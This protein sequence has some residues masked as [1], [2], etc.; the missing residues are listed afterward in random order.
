MTKAVP[1]EVKLRNGNPGKRKLPDTRPVGGRPARVPAAPI[2]L[3]P[4]ARRLWRTYVAPLMRGGVYDAADGEMVEVAVTLHRQLARI[5]R[6]VDG[7]ADADLVS[8]HEKTGVPHA[9]PLLAAERE[10]AG[11]LRLALGELGKGPVARTKLAPR[12]P[13]DVEHDMEREIGPSPRLRVVGRE[14]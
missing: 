3:D 1:T 4:Q 11:A 6:L 13:R 10:A 7:L 14:R 9:H 8:Y 2:G 5:R 12:T